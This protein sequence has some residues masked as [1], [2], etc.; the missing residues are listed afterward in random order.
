MTS[1]AIDSRSCARYRESEK[2]RQRGQADLMST[3]LVHV[4]TTPTTKRDDPSRSF[5]YALQ[6]ASSV[7]FPSDNRKTPPRTKDKIRQHKKLLTPRSVTLARSL[8]LDRSSPPPSFSPANALAPITRYK[9][10]R[11]KRGPI[12]TD[13]RAE[14]RTKAVG[15]W[16]N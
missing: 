14:F 9:A 16:R 12:T 7:Y 13:G 4:F 5:F 3:W 10:Y 6:R 8:H 11:R 2:E 15:V 1:A